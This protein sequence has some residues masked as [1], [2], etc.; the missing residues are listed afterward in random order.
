MPADPGAVTAG[1]DG[2]RLTVRE[3]TVKH[4][5]VQDA[6]TRFS[7]LLR[8]CQSI[9]PQLVTLRGQPVAVLVSATEWKSLQQDPRPSLK[10]LLLAN[11]PGFDLPLTDRPRIRPRPVD[12]DD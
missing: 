6:K 9:G 7:E 5:S 10:D 12:L 8:A 3:A 11:R 4:W 2:V 1:S